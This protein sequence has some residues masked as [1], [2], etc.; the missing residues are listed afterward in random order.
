MSQN[1]H[2]LSGGLKSGRGQP[3]SKTLRVF[4]RIGGRAS[5]LGVVVSTGHR[6]TANARQQRPIQI[7]GPIERGLAGLAFDIQASTNLLTW[8][9]VGKV[10]NVTGTV[11]YTNT[12]GA[13]FPRRFYRALQV[14]P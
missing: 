5:V 9:R 8:D 4:R 6:L 7:G 1:H 12:L 10:T 2:Y 3:H 14:S 11:Q 13:S